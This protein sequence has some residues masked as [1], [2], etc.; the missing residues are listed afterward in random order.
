VNTSRFSDSQ[1]IAI[2]KLAAAFDS[3][4]SQ[5]IVSPRWPALWD[6]ADSILT[7][8]QEA[9]AQTMVNSEQLDK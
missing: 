8:Y 6:K 1:I 4:S 3:K 7:Y 9:G 5:R 2:L